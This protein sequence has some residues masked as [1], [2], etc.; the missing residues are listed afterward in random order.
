MFQPIFRVR[1]VKEV[2]MKIQSNFGR[3]EGGRIGLVG[4]GCGS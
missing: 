2:E 1:K 4:I 3:G